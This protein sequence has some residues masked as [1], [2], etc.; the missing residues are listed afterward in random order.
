MCT[1]LKPHT[2]TIKPKARTTQNLLSIWSLAKMVVIPSCLLPRH[3]FIIFFLICSCSCTTY[4]IVSSSSTPVENPTQLVDHVCKNTTDYKFC[5]QAIYSDPRAPTADRYVLAYISF[6]LAYLNAT[7]TSD[8]ITLFLKNITA[9]GRSSSQQSLVRGLNVCQS[10]YQKAVRSLAEAI[11]DLDSE[12]FYELGRLACAADQA[13]GD[14]QATFSEGGGGDSLYYYS[15]FSLS[16]MNHNMRALAKIC[17]VVSKLFTV[18]WFL[19][20]LMNEKFDIHILLMQVINV[21]IHRYSSNP[22]TPI[23]KALII[24]Q[25]QSFYT[26]HNQGNANA[27][28]NFLT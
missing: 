13:A 2:Y 11:N 17:I 16:L 1:P 18:S 22:L 24:Q 27:P 21:H 9:R 5:V 8:Y 20:V 26:S 28:L 12:T 14:C 23:S 7:H 19:R 4:L 10:Y 6:D 25:W 3:D 15:I